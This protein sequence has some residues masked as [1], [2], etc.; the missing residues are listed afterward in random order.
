[1]VDI[2]DR[3]E[4]YYADKL[5][6][7]LPAIYRAEDPTSADDRGPLREIVNR[8]GAQG[9]VLRRGIDRLWEDQSIESCDDWVI[10]YLAELLATNLVASLDAR[11]QRIDVGKTIYYRRRKGT[12]ALLEEL[13]ADITGWNARVVEMFRRLGR[14]RHGLDP[15]LAMP[16][17]LTDATGAPSIPVVEGLIGRATRTPLGGFA[18]LRRRFGAS[19]AHTAFDEL[20]HTADVRLGRG[21]TG[22]HNIPHLGVFLWRLQS[23][24]LDGVTP[25]ADATCP[26]QYTFDPTGR[27]I[28]L[29]AAAVRSY[30]DQWVSP[31]EHELPGPI[32]RLLLENA[33]AALYAAVDPDGALLQNALRIYEGATTLS[34]LVKVDRVTADPRAAAT[35]Y[36]IDP[37][38]GRLYVPAGAPAS[39]LLVGYHHGF[40]SAIG[41]G[42]YDRRV[43]GEDPV[44]PS[45]VVATTGGAAAFTGIGPGG[46]VIKSG[47]ITITDSLTYTSAPSF[48]IDD[49]AGP[50]TLVV[51]ADNRRRPLIRLPAPA[52]NPA[53][54]KLTGT[55]GAD[56]RG[57]TLVL[58]G[59]FVS[60]GEVLLDGDFEQVT[61]STTTLD[62]GDRTAVAADGRALI[63]CRLRIK[64]R[65]KRLVIAR[66]IVGPVV[67]EAGALVEA[68]AIS[69]SII[70]AVDPAADALA[71]DTGLATIS[72]A[73]ILGTARL[74]Q[75][76][77]T[78]TI[79]HDVVKVADHQHGCVRFSAVPVGSVVPRP[80]ECV[81]ISPRQQLFAS[82][83]FGQPSYAQLL[84]SADPGVARGAEDGSELGAFWRENNPIK[85]RSLLIKYQ[86]FMPIG[87]A[88]VLIYVT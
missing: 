79:F 73:T 31:A 80:Y 39:H 60:G 67:M 43:R 88:P 24:P 12:V 82:R 49:S 57:S 9:A 47:T 19:R 32:D 18:D 28:P 8:I 3:Y 62:P 83:A 35:R 70:Q 48:T 36:F 87:L 29:F 40:S 51:R 26:N 53:V 5:W 21:A 1:M 23:V 16:L 69:D 54:W 86:E 22:W 71:I 17:E 14:A 63:P 74:H 85:E 27:N 15:A 84:A 61:L 38:A 64:G 66:S 59:V 77:A 76:E 65:I 34:N 4:A 25:V 42:G 30:G 58:D 7:L 75:I 6:A 37:R 46:T 11:G 44:L 56:H 2:P 13:A 50:N 33:L 52:P 55:T 41:A 68:L 10:A 81:T 78:T 72:A 20:S 45:P